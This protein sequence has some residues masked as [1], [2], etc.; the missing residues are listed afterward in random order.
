MKFS[1]N[2]LGLGK[3]NGNV[4]KIQRIIGNPVAELKKIG[5]LM[6]KSTIKT[7]ETEG[8]NLLGHKWKELADSTKK[9]RKRRGHTGKILTESGAL[10]RAQTY[11]LPK[12]KI[13]RWGPDV[14]GWYGKYHQSDK[15]RKRT[16]EGKIK[17]PR[18]QFLGASRK[19]KDMICNFLGKGIMKHISMEIRG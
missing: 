4:K 10:K 19:D 6:Q 14:T 1:S 7:F 11:E 17:L 2:V 3:L 9:A 15:P 18:R 12:P 5:I 13:L 16:K 8:V